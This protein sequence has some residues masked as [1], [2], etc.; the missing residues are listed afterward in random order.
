M[1][2]TINFH[3]DIYATFHGCP[4]IP[5]DDF[6][7][8]FDEDID[9]TFDDEAPEDIEAEA[10][11]SVILCSIDGMPDN[12]SPEMV[13]VI[14]NAAVTA[15]MEHFKQSEQSLSVTHDERSIFR[16]SAA[17]VRLFLPQSRLKGGMPHAG[18]SRQQD[19]HADDFHNEVDGKGAES[20]G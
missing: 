4:N 9:D 1:N 14:A 19:S 6:E 16:R 7:D 11:P 18:G 15:V 10:A 2:I 8:E 20:G 12:I 17:L 3:G 13:S 5:Y